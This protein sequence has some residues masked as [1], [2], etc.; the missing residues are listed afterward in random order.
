MKHRERVQHWPVGE[1]RNR[2]YLQQLSRG[3]YPSIA[4]IVS[5]RCIDSGP[6]NGMIRCREWRVWIDTSVSASGMIR[7]VNGWTSSP[8]FYT[9]FPPQVL[10]LC[11][12]MACSNPARPKLSLLSLLFVLKHEMFETFEP[13]C[14]QPI[15]HTALK[16]QNHQYHTLRIFS[17]AVLNRALRRASSSSP[18]LL[19]VLQ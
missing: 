6:L 14:H 17:S 8:K 15:Y 9:Y 16:T 11:F 19:V 2:P 5:F 4:T 13:H 10:L 18:P 1:G 3:K 12:R 7:R